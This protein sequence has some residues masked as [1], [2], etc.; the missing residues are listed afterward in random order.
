MLLLPW[1]RQKIM[2]IVRHIA[3]F[4][5]P[6]SRLG[7]EHAKISLVPTMGALHAGH[8]SLVEQAKK[9]SDHVVVS[10]FVN[11]TQFDPGEDFQKY[12]RTLGQDTALLDKMGVSS[13]FVPD[14]GEIYPEGFKTYVVVED[15][16]E[17]LCGVS[18]PIHFCGVTT[19]VLKLLNIVQPDVAVFG[20]KDAQQCVIVRRMMIDL[21][22]DVE[23]VVCPIIREADGLA[24][25]SRN[26]YLKATE[27]KAATILYQ[28]LEWAREKV[29]QGETCAE[30]ILRGVKE[31]IEK[32]PLARLDYAEIVDAND[33][34]AI[35]TI[36]ENSLL[37]L[38]VFIGNIRLIDNILLESAF[39]GKNV[40]DNMAQA[41][42]YWMSH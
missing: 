31:R 10:I 7:E 18:R 41:P 39:L 30:L 8:L 38:A 16:S 34:S 27:R 20:Q 24:M 14:I 11:P 23:I 35:K 33:L 28:C 21:N 37:A 1:S 29:T 42:A 32:E 26:R 40:D 4:K 3:D 9:I 6:R 15:L 19:I 12:P 13:V 25:S 5:S 36:K 22:L 2:Q 17:R